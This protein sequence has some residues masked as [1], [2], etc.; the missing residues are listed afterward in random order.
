MNDLQRKKLTKQI[1]T[2]I[3]AS[4]AIVSVASAADTVTYT[5]KSG[6]TIYSLAMAYNTTVTD[7][8]AYNNLNS[9]SLIHPNQQ[10][11]IP[12][13]TR[14]E[15]QLVSGGYLGGTGGSS[16]SVNTGSSNA[17]GSTSA[18]IYYTVRSGDTLSGIAQRYGTTVNQ[19]ASWNG[20]RDVSMI[21]AGTTL[22]VGNGSFGG[23]ASTG[24]SSSS[25]GG[26]ATGA[27]TYYTVK[28]GDTLSGIAAAYGTTVNQLASLNGIANVHLIRTGTTLKVSNGSST[29]TGST[30]T[31]STGSTASGQYYTVQSG[32]TLSGIA[33][34]YGQ[35]ITDLARWNNVPNVNMIHAGVS[36]LVNPYSSG[37]TGSGS[38]SGSSDRELASNEYRVVSGDNLYTLAIRFNTTVSQL[39][40][41]NNIQNTRLIHVG[42]ILQVSGTG[43][44][45]SSNTA[46]AVAPEV[47]T[48]APTT[49]EVTTPVTPEVS[50]PVTPEVTAPDLSDL[51]SPDL[52]EPTTPDLSEPD[53][54]DVS[55]PDLDG[56]FV[57]PDVGISPTEEPQFPSSD[58]S[59]VTGNV[60]GDIMQDIGDLYDMLNIEATTMSDVTV[61]M[62]PADQI[63]L[64]VQMAAEAEAAMMPV[65]VPADMGSSMP[66]AVMLPTSAGGL[67]ENEYRVESESTIFQVAALFNASVG[68]LLS[69]NQVADAN[70]IPAG[71]VLQVKA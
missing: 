31:G 28:S 25:G 44:S 26:S 16:G 11:V 61:E 66:G 63:A 68:E 42:D 18:G 38:S 43:S 46:G 52:S 34:A 64:E 7:I 23:G 41:W 33:A 58:S 13:N 69:L 3:M 6:D 35:S 49:P 40:S 17:G 27:G 12:V 1:S 32:D 48:P 45:V 24:G 19:L 39:A 60:S 59:P 67:T 65:G 55:T 22:L 50:A 71:T 9:S 14:A 10:L 57:T 21:R 70:A 51:G 56:D 15:G 2:A 62:E 8:Y 20:I 53:F 5:V 30:S 29:S 37:S 36:L 4:T 54:G 47:S